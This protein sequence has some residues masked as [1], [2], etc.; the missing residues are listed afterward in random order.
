MSVSDAVVKGVAATIS[1]LISDRAAKIP[2]DIIARQ[3][4]K[5][6]AISSLDGLQ[7]ALIVS[8][9]REVAASMVLVD[10]QLEILALKKRIAELESLASGPRREP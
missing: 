2:A 1:A 10:F 6:R 7:R 4:H 3:E 9:G 5:I 8:I